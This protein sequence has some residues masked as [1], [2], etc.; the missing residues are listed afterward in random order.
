MLARGTNNIEAWQLCVRATE[1]FM[2]FNSSDY[3]D[4]RALAEKAIA[5]DSKFAYAWATLGFTYWWDG[6]LGYTGDS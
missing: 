6:R 1:L 3:L 4:A 5:R 2:R